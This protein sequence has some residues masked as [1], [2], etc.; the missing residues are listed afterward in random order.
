MI[1]CSELYGDWRS[2]DYESLTYKYW[3]KMDFTIFT[4]GELLQ[5][6][7]TMCKTKLPVK[8]RPQHR[9]FS[10]EI[11]KIFK[12]TYFEEQ[13]RTAASGTPSHKYKIIIQ[14]VLTH[15]Y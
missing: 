1:H 9:F 11:W 6:V 5:N 14:T 3:V 13:L 15:S 12:S 7:H 2:I 4:K 8:K 10:C